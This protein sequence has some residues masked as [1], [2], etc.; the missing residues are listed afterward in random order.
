MENKEIK[1]FYILIGEIK[2]INEQLDNERSDFYDGGHS[3][4]DCNR[5][6]FEELKEKE[7]E[8]TKILVNLSNRQ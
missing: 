3:F 6:L 1:R 7:E 4:E 5:F 8:F 2:E